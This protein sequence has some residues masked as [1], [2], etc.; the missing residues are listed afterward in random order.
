M[1]HDGASTGTSNDNTWGLVLLMARRVTNY[2]MGTI[3][4]GVRG[5]NFNYGSNNYDNEIDGLV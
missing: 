1:S 2:K 4:G 3:D 5:T